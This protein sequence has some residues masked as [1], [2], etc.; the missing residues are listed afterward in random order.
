MCLWYAIH[1]QTSIPIRERSGKGRW[2][3]AP[4][5]AKGMYP[6]GIPVMAGWGLGLLA[7]LGRLC[8]C[9]FSCGWGVRTMG[10]CP[11]PRQMDVSLWNPGNGWQGAWF[12]RRPWAALPALFQLWLVSKDDG[13]LPHTLPK[14]L[15]PFGIPSLADLQPSSGNARLSNRWLIYSPTNVSNAP[16][17]ANGW[18]ASCKIIHANTIVT[19]GVR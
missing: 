8:L 13:A 14:G 12:A 18:I 19:A 11:I 4:Y 1:V 3:S 2:G 9:A 5:P 16:T 15:H 6:F 7:A 10:R 17:I